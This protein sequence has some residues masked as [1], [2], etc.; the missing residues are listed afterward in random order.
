MI[1]LLFVKN[2]PLNIHYYYYISQ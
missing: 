1:N 2:N